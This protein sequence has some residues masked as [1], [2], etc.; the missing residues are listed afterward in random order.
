M[1]ICTKCKKRKSEKEFYLRRGDR[2]GYSTH[3]IKCISEHQRLYR[4]KNNERLRKKEALY[5][6][7]NKDKIR[8]RVLAN[9][10]KTNKARCARK[11]TKEGRKK[12]KAEQRR[13]RLK[14]YGLTM[15]AFDS[16]FRGQKGKCAICN[17]ELVDENNKGRKVSNA[18]PRID[19]CHKTGKIRGLLCNR[20]NVAMGAFDDDIKLIAKVAIYLE[21]ANL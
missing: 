10:D 9:K 1:K 5:R 19:H 16:L 18:Y 12:I 7:T 2:K 3:C 14:K 11:K 8:A 4:V 15:A 6:L 17:L 13:Y 21:R 20:C